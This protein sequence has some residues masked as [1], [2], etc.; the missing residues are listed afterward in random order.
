[1]IYTEQAQG[2]DLRVLN[3]YGQSAARVAAFAAVRTRYP[4]PAKLASA[5]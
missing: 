4:R 3:A 2:E 1:M 5:G